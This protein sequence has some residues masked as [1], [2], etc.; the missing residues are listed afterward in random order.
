MTQNDER[1]RYRVYVVRGD[2]ALQMATFRR[3]EDAEEYM[4]GFDDEMLLRD[5]ET[6]DK[7]LYE[8]EKWK[9]AFK[10]T[11]DCSSNQ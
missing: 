2:Y 9:D 11:R 3:R 10:Q 1:L 5:M 7:I 8:A 4:A 6:D